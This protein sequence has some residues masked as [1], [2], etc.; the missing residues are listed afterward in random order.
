MR[1]SLASALDTLRRKGAAIDVVWQGKVKPIRY[2]I[3]EVLEDGVL[4]SLAEPPE[5]DAALHPY[6]AFQSITAVEPEEV[7]PDPA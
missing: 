2:C 7:Q 5:A 1:R 3:H 6:S 4:L